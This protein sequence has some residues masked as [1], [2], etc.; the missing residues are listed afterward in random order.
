MLWNHLEEKCWCHICSLP[1]S[2][3]F[4]DVF[5]FSLGYCKHFRL[6]AIWRNGELLIHGIVDYLSQFPTMA[7]EKEKYF[8]QSLLTSNIHSTSGQTQP[9]GFQYLFSPFVRESWVLAECMLNTIFPNLPC[10]SVWSDSG[11]RCTRE[12]F[13]CDFWEVSLSKNS[14]LLPFF[15]FLLPERWQDSQ[16][17]SNHHGS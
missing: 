5:L 3:I 10:A 15:S 6:V 4:L 7:G 14:A 12:S 17:L 1:F 2:W 8:T 9:V 13:M 11:Q 16:S